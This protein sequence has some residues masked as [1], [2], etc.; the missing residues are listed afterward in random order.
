MY[1]IDKFWLCGQTAHFG[2]LCGDWGC[3]WDTLEGDCGEETCR[4][5]TDVGG[6]AGKTD[7]ASRKSQD[8]ESEM[9][10]MVL[11]EFR[12]TSKNGWDYFSYK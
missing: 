10:A 9:G 4:A 12:V 2:W 5:M 6:Y 8:P 11:P 3:R 1:D 7:C